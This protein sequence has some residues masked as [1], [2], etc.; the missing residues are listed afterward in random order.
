MSFA[1]TKVVGDEAEIAVASVFFEAGWFV[2]RNLVYGRRDLAVQSPR[3]I[4]LVEVKNETA[5]TESGNLCIE[6]LQGRP[7]RPSGLAIS[8]ST[9]CIHVLGEVCALYRTQPMRLWLKERNAIARPFGKSDNGNQ[10]VIV[11]IGELVD[12]AWFDQKRI[13]DLPLSHLF[14]D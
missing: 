3:G 12:H 14:Q 6:L 4:Q 13:S 9:I 2:K 1:A 7:A 8:E 10:G 5:F 11:R